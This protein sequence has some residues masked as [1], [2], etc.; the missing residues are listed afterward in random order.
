MRLDPLSE[1]SDVEDRRD[2]SGNDGGSGGL[3]GGLLGGGGR[4][5]IGSMILAA[6]AYLVF[7][8]SPST[9]VGL[10]CC[11]VYVTKYLVGQSGAS[12][13]LH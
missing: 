2:G 4:L 9:V 8:I 12:R 11:T 5:G 6:V 7:G 3:L 13:D 1:S 10:G